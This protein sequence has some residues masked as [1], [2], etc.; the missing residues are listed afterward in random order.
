MS[1]VIASAIRTNKAPAP[2]AGREI[3]RGSVHMDYQDS[4][5]WLS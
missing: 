5:D 1:S 4:T 2:D 3:E